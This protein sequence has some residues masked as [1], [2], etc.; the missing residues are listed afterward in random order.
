MQLHSRNFLLYLLSVAFL[1]IA[2]TTTYL[3]GRR[4]SALLPWQR[5][6]NETVEV[7]YD[8]VV[9]ARPLPDRNARLQAWRDEIGKIDFSETISAPVAQPVTETVD[10]E[11]AEAAGLFL[12]QN[13]P[14]N[15]VPNW[16]KAE[17]K[18]A[19]VEGAR[20]IYTETPAPVIASSTEIAAPLKNVL[21]QL[22]LSSFPGK[23]QSC[24]AS[25]VIGVATDGSLIR[26]S[27]TS[28]YSV[29]G[30]ETLIGYALDGFP[31]YGAG[32]LVTDRCGGVVVAGE[33]RYLLAKSRE[34][35]LN[36]FAGSPT[37]W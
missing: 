27:E 6:N 1:I 11:P 19:V 32:D 7:E 17:V 22:P 15:S 5:E 25:E 35:M 31:I 14:V 3:D 30:S 13:Y 29:F 10:I 16:P 23:N 12:C 37:T 24:I 36:C 26:N 9:S 21:L 34:T 8:A 20:L 33:Y 28:L 2:I 4:E 18:L